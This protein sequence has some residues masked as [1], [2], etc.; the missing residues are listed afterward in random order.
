MSETIVGLAYVLESE[1]A[2]GRTSPRP[3]VRERICG[4]TNIPLPTWESEFVDG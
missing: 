1:F 4:Q 2:D 3:C